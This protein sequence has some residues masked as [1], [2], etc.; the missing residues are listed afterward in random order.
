MQLHLISIIVLTL[1]AGAVLGLNLRPQL[2]EANEFVDVF[3]CGWPMTF[4]VNV[5]EHET[6]IMND[7]S[8]PLRF[9]SGS[10]AV[11]SEKLAAFE[12]AQ[13]I[14]TYRP[15]RIAV[16]LASAVLIVLSVTVLTE[17][18]ARRRHGGATA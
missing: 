16:D 9:G 10:H 5:I 15:T 11:T 18:L 13:S 4:Q 14:K 17:W 6:P 12:R 7:I 2:I 8:L 3:A 1:S